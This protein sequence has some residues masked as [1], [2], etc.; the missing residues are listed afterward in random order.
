M[1]RPGDQSTQQGNFD[2]S[3]T[4][5][6]AV[7]P[8]VTAAFNSQSNPAD[9]NRPPAGAVATRSPTTYILPTGNTWIQPGTA[10]PASDEEYLRTQAAAFG[11]PD[12][13]NF[14]TPQ[15]VAFYTR[16]YGRA[17]R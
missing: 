10:S 6:G 3:G 9:P 8:A 16:M 13:T 14:V 12:P 7:D 17:P 15:Q 5:G 11:P 4:G 2:F 1:Q